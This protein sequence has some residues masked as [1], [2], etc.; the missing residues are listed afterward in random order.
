MFYLIQVENDKKWELGDGDGGVSV[1]FECIQKFIYDVWMI[2]QWKK[3]RKH[4]G[5]ANF[6]VK[7]F[8]SVV[9]EFFE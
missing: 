7:I 6:E 5:N 8:E 1:G 4:E 3:W 9:M 2:I